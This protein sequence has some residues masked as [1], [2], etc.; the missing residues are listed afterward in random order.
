MTL[1]P[2]DFALTQ[3]CSSHPFELQTH[4]LF[5]GLTTNRYFKRND[6][7]VTRHHSDIN[8]LATTYLQISSQ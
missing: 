3:P 7:L 4:R 1:C 2:H 5:E 8:L 6:F